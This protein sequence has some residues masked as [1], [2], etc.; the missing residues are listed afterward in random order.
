MDKSG[1]SCFPST[2]RLSEET[3]LSE[4]T[5]CTHLEIAEKEGWIQKMQQGL[6]GRAWKR[7][8]YQALIPQKALKEIQHLEVKGT[9]GGSV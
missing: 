4:R 5:V 3:G 2:K 7:H 8:S 9:E 6:T 1:G